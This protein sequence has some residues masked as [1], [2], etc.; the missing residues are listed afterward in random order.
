VCHNGTIASDNFKDWKQS[1]HAAIFTK[2]INDPNGHWAIA[3]AQCHSV[4]YD[5]KATNGGF[6]EAVKVENWTVPPHGDVG[7]WTGMLSKNPKTAK[8]AN[9]QCENCHGPNEGST[10]HG[11]KILDP[12]RISVSAD[13]CGSCHG[14][15]PRHVRF[16]QWEGSGH[17]NFEVAIDEA[18]VEN[19]G[20]TAGHCGRCHSAQGF[21]SWIAQGDLTKQIQGAKGNAT[22]DELKALGLT[23]STVQPQ[24]CVVCHDPHD[25]GHSSSLPNTAT[26]P[27]RGG[28]R[29][30]A[31]FM[32][33]DLPAPLRPMRPSTR[34][35]PASNDTPCSTWLSP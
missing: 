22:V 23:K 8:L 20:A 12:A 13:V 3:C 7:Y 25:P 1:G 2:N 30:T 26:V 6:D 5:P 18:T 24:T 28:S 19:R 32:Q 34:P 33:V 14:E 21:L 27:A 31:T 4:G 17:A 35:A 10:L 11:N 9:I 15:P 29:P 16:Q